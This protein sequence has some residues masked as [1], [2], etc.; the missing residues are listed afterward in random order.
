M[1]PTLLSGGDDND[2]LYGDAGADELRGGAGNDTLY[3]DADDTVIEGGEG[4]D[5]LYVQGSDG[6]TI[7]LAAAASSRPMAIPATTAS[8]APLSRRIRPSTAVTATTP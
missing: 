8:M 3:V 1:A 6:L 4:T 2:S 5:K 7:D